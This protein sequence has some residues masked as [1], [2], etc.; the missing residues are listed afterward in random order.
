MLEKVTASMELN[1]LAPAAGFS[2]DAKRKHSLD[3]TGAIPAL[4]C[5]FVVP[6]GN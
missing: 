4:G 1:D 2:M 5:I 3:A 6:A